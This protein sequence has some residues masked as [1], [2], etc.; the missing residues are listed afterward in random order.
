M[1]LCA[2]MFY[3]FPVSY[4]CSSPESSCMQY[5]SQRTWVAESQM[6]SRVGMHADS[7]GG[8]TLCH[9]LPLQ[10]PTL[11]L[12]CLGNSPSLLLSCICLHSSALSFSTSH[13]LENKSACLSQRVQH[14]TRQVANDHVFYQRTE[15][16]CIYIS[17]QANQAK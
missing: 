8:S 3:V 11:F 17:L 15:L 13:V 1:Q 4:S 9:S 14:V 7:Q 10:T 2:H 5:D 16:H 12:V 6:G